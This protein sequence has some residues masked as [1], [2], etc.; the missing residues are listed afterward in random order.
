MPETDDE[1]LEAL[2]HMLGD[3]KLR[4]KGRGKTG[5]GPLEG[6]GL[7]CRYCNR[8]HAFKSLDIKYRKEKNETFT[9]MWT[10]HLTGYVIA[11]QPK[12]EEPRRP[13]GEL[14]GDVAIGEEVK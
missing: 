4:D 12:G 8:R 7:W 13:L 5:G 11:D 9:I 14:A 6:G 2:H 10:C 1:A 3:R